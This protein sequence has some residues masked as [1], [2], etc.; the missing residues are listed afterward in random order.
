M[1]GVVGYVYPKLQIHHQSILQTGS[2]WLQLGLLVLLELRVVK[3]ILG[4]LE[5]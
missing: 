5:N 2:Y 4:L 1:G 3:V